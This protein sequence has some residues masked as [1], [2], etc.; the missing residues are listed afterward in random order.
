MNEKWW[1]EGV[2][3]KGNK[4]K[5][6]PKLLSDELISSKK[7]CGGLLPPCTP[8]KYANKHHLKSK[9]ANN[10]KKKGKKLKKK[11]LSILEKNL[12]YVKP[13]HH[14]LY[15]SQVKKGPWSFLKHAKKH[16]VENLK[17]LSKNRPLDHKISKF[18]P[19]WGGASAA[20]PDPPGRTFGAPNISSLQNSYVEP[21]YIYTW[22]V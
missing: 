22:K 17:K 8:P 20:P 21:C 11:I 9:I 15:Q 3:K 7:I 1:K 2:R 16:C 19:P 18:S 4:R 14:P 5:K 12:P 10:C 6:C 13:W